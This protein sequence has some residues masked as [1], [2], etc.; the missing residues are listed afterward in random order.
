MIGANSG[1]ENQQQIS[2]L[3]SYVEDH[4]RTKGIDPHV[5][6][7]FLDGKVHNP[8][9]L[10]DPG[11]QAYWK[12]AYLQLTEILDP[13]ILQSGAA[14]IDFVNLNESS[15][16]RA[17]YAR[18]TASSYEAEEESAVAYTSSSSTATTSTTSSTS[19]DVDDDDDNDSDE[20][21]VFAGGTTSYTTTGS[22]EYTDEAAR[23]M[24]DESGMSGDMWDYLINTEEGIRSGENY[25]LNGLAEI[26]Q[27]IADLQEALESGELTPE[28]FSAQVDQISAYR[29]IYVGMIQNFE[30]AWGN[31]VDMYSQLLKSIEEAFLGIARNI[32]SN[33]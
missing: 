28:E 29:Q 24:A 27:Q 9:I 15:T 14:E 1:I 4:C 10:N 7:S 5:Y 16:R 2:E 25:V 19:S 8:E 11:F 33:S 6:T 22:T 32:K 13:T 23:D 18:T 26:D 12:L 21:V 20:E 3:K 31:I 30:D 17:S